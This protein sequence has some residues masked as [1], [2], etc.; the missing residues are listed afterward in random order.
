MPLEG[1]LVTALVIIDVEDPTLLGLRVT[2]P[3]LILNSERS[4]VINFY[5]NFFFFFCVSTM[6]DHHQP[7]AFS[8]NERVSLAVLGPL[9]SSACSISGASFVG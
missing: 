5:F 6:A 7:S 3:C 8:G 9:T 4:G 1:G 2:R